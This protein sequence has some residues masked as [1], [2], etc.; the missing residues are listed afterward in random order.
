[1]IY[2]AV[3]HS[4]D[5]PYILLNEEQS[6]DKASNRTMKYPSVNFSVPVDIWP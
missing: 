1:M 4:Y 3:N 6:K 2:S 5:F